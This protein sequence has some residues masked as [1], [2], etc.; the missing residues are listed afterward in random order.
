MRMK[1]ALCFGPNTN[2]IVPLNSVSK[3]SSDR[4]IVTGSLFGDHV[5]SAPPISLPVVIGKDRFGANSV[6]FDSSVI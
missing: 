5:F 3:F 4:G 1:Q 6:L 2:T